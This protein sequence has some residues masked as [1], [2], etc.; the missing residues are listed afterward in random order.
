MTTAIVVLNTGERVICDLQEVRENDDENGKPICLLLI[1]PYILNL[2]KTTGESN[3]QEVQV[4]FSKWLPYSSDTQF[5]IGFNSVLAI[6]AADVG[7]V[8][9]YSQ[10]VQ[11]AIA[12]EEQAMKTIVSQ[13]PSAQT[14]VVTADDQDTEV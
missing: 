3:S 5:R 13:E 11:Q 8:E 10:T 4:R 7:L 6:G 14:S 9:A 12:L 1:R 2:E